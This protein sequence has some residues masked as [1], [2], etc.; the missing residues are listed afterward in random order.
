M[1]TTSRLRVLGF[2]LCALTVAA[3]AWAQTAPNTATPAQLAKYDANKNGR[4]D[5]E[6]LSAMQLDQARTAPGVADL[7][8]P[9]ELSPFQVSTNRD[10]GYAAENTTAGS[11]LATPLTDLAASITVITKQQMEDTAAL[12]INDV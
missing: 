10:T 6:E 11:R 9:L 3:I 5:P 4:L 2:P 7:D 12:D 1:N 8:K